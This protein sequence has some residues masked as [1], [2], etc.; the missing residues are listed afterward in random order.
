MQLEETDPLSG[1]TMVL[2]EQDANYLWRSRSGKAAPAERLTHLKAILKISTA[3]NSIRDL[4]ALER[5]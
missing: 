3:I 5:A 2:Q 4:E 1:T